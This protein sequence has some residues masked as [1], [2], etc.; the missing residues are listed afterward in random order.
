MIR[1]A[2]CEDD[3]RYRRLLLKVLA[4]EPELQVVGLATCGEEACDLV[5][6]EQPEVLLLDLEL[7]GLNGLEVLQRLSPLP[8]TLEVLILTSFSDE[9]RV[10]S[11]IQ[12]GAAGYL[13]KGL[14][15]G[16]LVAAIREVTAGGTVIEARLAR[17]FWNLFASV[18]GHS[19][20]DHDLTPMELEVLTMVGRGLS[21]PEAARALGASRGLIKLHLQHIYRKLGVTNRVAATVKALQLGVIQL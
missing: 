4:V 1:L 15:P 19:A 16:Q 5:E 6:R 9:E 13:V 20:A 8:T 18:Q 7:P 12:A 10:F 3:A 11:A 17:R 2:I 14:S 21:N